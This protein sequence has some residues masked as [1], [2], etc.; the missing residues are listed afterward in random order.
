[1]KVGELKM[2]LKDIDDERIVILSNDSEGNSFSPLE[3]LDISS[4]YL[5]ENECYGE[6]GIEELTPEL[7]E[8][9]YKQDDVG[10]E[11]ALVLWPVN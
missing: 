7:K 4:T 6:I 9:G 11:N 10:G 8:I 1:M 2:L 5:A 3:N